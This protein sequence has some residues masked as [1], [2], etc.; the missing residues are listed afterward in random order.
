MRARQLNTPRGKHIITLTGLIQILSGS[1]MVPS[2]QTLSQVLSL[3]HLLDDHFRSPFSSDLHTCLP[4]PSRQDDNLDSDF[5]E[6]TEAVR[7]LPHLPP[8]SPNHQH[9]FSQILPPPAP[10]MNSPAPIQS[11]QLH[12]GTRSAPFSPQ[13]PRF[14]RSCLSYLIHFP[15]YTGPFSSASILLFLSS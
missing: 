5:T 6:K 7:E 8:H 13:G 10:Q 3:P 9:V 11:Q 15:L 14:S 1:V 2:N 12:L 4:L